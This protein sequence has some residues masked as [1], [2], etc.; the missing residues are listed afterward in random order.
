[1]MACCRAPLD[2]YLLCLLVYRL[3][4]LPLLCAQSLPVP[5]GGLDTID[6]ITGARLAD[7]GGVSLPSAIGATDPMTDLEVAQREAEELEV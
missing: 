1:M 3:L 4:I 5:R 7:P 6:I 2:P